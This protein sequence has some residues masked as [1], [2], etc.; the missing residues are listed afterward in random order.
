[1]QCD[2]NIILIEETDGDIAMSSGPPFRGPSTSHHS[3]VR[4]RGVPEG[5]CLWVTAVVVAFSRCR[6]R[7]EYGRINGRKIRK[8]PARV[9]DLNVFDC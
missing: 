5:S 8:V 1:V 6:R 7:I 9:S 2:D 3:G 4:H